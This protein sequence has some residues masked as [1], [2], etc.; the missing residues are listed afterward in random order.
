MSSC[1]I[2]VDDQTM[3]AVLSIFMHQNFTRARSESLIWLLKKKASS[4][5]YFESFKGVLVLVLELFE[6]DHSDSF[7][8]FRI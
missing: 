1:E 5:H 3:E 8:L 6:L 2:T 4:G 7:F